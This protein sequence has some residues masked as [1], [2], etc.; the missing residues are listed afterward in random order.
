MKALHSYKQTLRRAVLVIAP[1]VL[2]GFISA[3]EDK[4][5]K[6]PVAAPVAA[7]AAPT[8]QVNVAANQQESQ[9]VKEVV[10]KRFRPARDPFQSLYTGKRTR[11]GG[12]A[13]TTTP[14]QQYSIGQ[15][16]LLGIIWGVA[17]PVGLVA[18]P[19]GD[20]YIV[21]TGTPVGTGDG[22]VVAVLPDRIVIVEKYY[23]YRG[24]LQT[25][26]YELALAD[27]GK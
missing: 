20:E 7:P 21:K 9:V 2:A 11:V 27:Q 19:T 26:K 12:G 24:Q 23:D 5:P 13:T 14:L 22:K 17:T 25:E 1:A 15:L 6:P 10:V 16:R 18:T 4:K 8:P 3:C